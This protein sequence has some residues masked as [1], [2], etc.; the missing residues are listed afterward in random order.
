MVAARWFLFAVFVR[1]SSMCRLAYLLLLVPAVAWS[2][3]PPGANL[4]SLDGNNLSLAVGFPI[5]GAAGP[6]VGEVANSGDFDE[7]GR[8]YIAEAGGAITKPEVAE[9][10][11]A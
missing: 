9:Q 2:Q 11:P 10:K 1:D 6:A 4:I 3:S 8:L 5:G 7:Q